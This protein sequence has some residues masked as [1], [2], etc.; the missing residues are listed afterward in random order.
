LELARAG[1]GEHRDHYIKAQG[2]AAERVA[3]KEMGADGQVKDLNADPATN[4]PIYDAVSDQRVASVKC[5]GLSDDDGTLSDSVLNAYIRDFEEAIGRGT[6]PTKFH[7]AVQQLHD[8]ARTEVSGYPRELVK[9]P[10]AAEEYLR[11]HAELWLPTDHA[12]AVRNELERRLHSDD[13]IEQ[14]VTA[15]RLGLDLLSSTYES[16]VWETL[17][18]IH[19]LGINSTEIKVLLDREFR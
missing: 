12:T 4:F 6:D 15:S 17:V 19:G 8:R 7:K 9:S 18:R 1:I 10:E 14:E 5:K 3:L 13:P 2:R 11:M 16:D